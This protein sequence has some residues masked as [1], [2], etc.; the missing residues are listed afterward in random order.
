MFPLSLT[1]KALL[2]PK[3]FL[4]PL[5]VCSRYPVSTRSKLNAWKTILWWLGHH[6]NLINTFSLSSVPTEIFSSLFSWK[7]WT[8][9]TV[10]AIVLKK[11]NVFQ[12]FYTIYLQLATL[13]IWN[14]VKFKEIR[15]T[16]ESCTDIGIWNKCVQRKNVIHGITGFPFELSARVLNV[17]FSRNLIGPL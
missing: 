3:S 12:T 1:K 5:P 17:K 8:N 7:L 2:I 14:C 16:P 13:T 6:I 11:K 9:V 15:I 4:R 10:F